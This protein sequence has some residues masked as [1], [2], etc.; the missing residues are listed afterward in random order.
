[1][2]KT[3]K[4]DKPI[5]LLSLALLNTAL[6]IF[7][8]YS[9]FR[10]DG[11]T[12]FLELFQFVSHCLALNLVVCL[13]LFSVSFLFRRV[14]TYLGFIVYGLFQILLFVDVRVYDLFRFHINSLVWNNIMT[15][16]F[17]DSVIIGKSS[18][19][20][21]FFTAVL[22]FLLEGVFIYVSVRASR[23][24]RGKARIALVVLCLLAIAGDKVIYAFGDAYNVQPIMRASMLYPLYQSVHPEKTL[25]RFFHIKVKREDELKM[26][27][28]G[29]LLN[30]PKKPL[31]MQEKKPLRPYIVMIAVE[32]FRYDMLDPEITPNLWKFARG[33]IIF[34]NHFSG[35]N[36]TRAGIF[37]LLYGLQ[38][39]YWHSFLIEKKSPVLID[40][41]RALG[42]EFKILSATQ[43]SFPEFRK[44]IFVRVEDAI[45][46]RLP[47][48]HSPAG[49]SPVRDKMMVDKFVDFVSKRNPSRPF[50]FYMFFNSSHQPYSYPDGFAK[51]RP[52]SGAE[53]NYTKEIN[54]SNVGP[55]KNRYKNALYYDDSLFGRIFDSLR[56]KNLLKNTIVII[57]GDHGEEFYERGYFG[58]TSSFDDYETKVVFV[59]HMPGVKAMEVDKLTSHLDFVPT[60]MK[61]LGYSNPPSDYSQGIPLLDAEKHSYVFS[62][63]WDRICMIDKDIKIVF[64]TESYMTYLDVLQ[65]GTYKPFPDPEKILKEKRN[66]TSDV[67]RKM[68]EFYR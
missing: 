21:I 41:L 33:N 42:Y 68:S 67:L 28:H 3:E 4:K 19:L 44:T 11:A 34:K 54:A 20:Y 43:L 57:T 2:I 29:S 14:L 64:S 49:R 47:A 45:E 59:M 46:D 62:A 56:E 50:F 36:G 13:V 15:E 58:H 18:F 53:I 12:G 39:T 32:G 16:G 51:F 27:P 9:L 66:K 8:S 35:G 22:I 60:I 25:A 48:G 31:V 6:S 38:G 61:E 55:V 30:Y 37:S 7:I 23:I 5:S 63:G 10:H 17:S 24:L 65:A 26:S 40:S 52:V 1:M